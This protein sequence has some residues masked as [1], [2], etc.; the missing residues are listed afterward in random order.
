M[1]FVFVEIHLHRKIHISCP[2]FTG[3]A[4]ALGLLLLLKMQSS[5]RRGRGRRP[6]CSS[7]YLSSTSVSRRR[8]S[9][10]QNGIIPNRNKSSGLGRTRSVGFCHQELCP[11]P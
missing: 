2:S 5:C 6:R 3:G 9:G 10:V 7:T 11:S 1:E 4:V 8:P